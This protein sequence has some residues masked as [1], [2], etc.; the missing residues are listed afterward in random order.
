MSINIV[1][2]S[3][4]LT[5]DC[6]LRTTA[7]GM[8]VISLT[9]AVNERKKDAN[10]NWSSVANFIDCTMFG[11]RAEKIASYLTKGSKVAIEGRLHQSSWEKDGHKRS[12]I[13]VIVNEIEFTSKGEKQATQTYQP[14]EDTS[15]YDTEIP[16]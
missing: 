11:T 16:F 5:K 6:E 10:G 1:C 8:A 4:N 15:V 13:E 2:I 3:G 7:S 12:K 9:V 14:S